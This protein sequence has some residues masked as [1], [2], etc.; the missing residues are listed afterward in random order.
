MKNAA[1]VRVTGQMRRVERMD[2]LP[3]VCDVPRAKLGR[4]KPLAAGRRLRKMPAGIPA[5]GKK[6]PLSD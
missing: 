4:R 2:E 5:L 3:L 1:I 6:L